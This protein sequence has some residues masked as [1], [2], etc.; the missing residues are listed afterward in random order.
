MRRL[1]QAGLILVVVLAGSSIAASPAS[2]ASPTIL[3]LPGAKFPVKFTGKGGTGVLETTAG[4]KVTC[5][6]DTESGE[7]TSTT[8]GVITLDST[9][10][11]EGKVA[12]SS[13][14]TKGEKDPKET[15]LL[16]NAGLG[17]VSVMNA[18]KE[19]AVGLSIT[20]AATLVLSCGL[21][22]MEVKGATAGLI[23]PFAKGDTESA[24]VAL[25]QKAGKAEIG[26]CVESKANCEKLAKEP[27]EANFS[28]KF[29][30]AAE[31]VSRELAFSQMLEIAYKGLEFKSTTG[32]AANVEGTNAG[33]GNHVFNI[34][35]GAAAGLRSLIICK[36]ATF[37]AAIAATA[38]TIKIK[39]SYTECESFN[40][41][42][43]VRLALTVAN[44]CEYEFS[45][46]VGA[47][48]YAGAMA[49]TPACELKFTNPAN[50]E[51]TFKNQA[52]FTGTT[53]TNLGMPA[54]EL[55]FSIKIA[56]WKF[57]VTC[58]GVGTENKEGEY[59]GKVRIPGV[60]IE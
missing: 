33:L 35:E 11:K 16:T 12:C 48:P 8:E 2:A 34:T 38:A 5:T 36:G 19:L 32:A 50:C 4:K 37:K 29:E 58:P 1:R 21:V 26:E 10:C 56:K 17:L 9:G 13:E 39:P 55:E 24:V 30:P 59:E 27:L 40:E 51:V 47:G 60:K 22:K 44:T 7:L 43:N 31:E 52:P 6:G 23:S 42:L 28:G 57:Q 3:L 14:A 25:K 53:F 18:A 54:S 45:N 41:M 46:L 49:V 20:P 15:I